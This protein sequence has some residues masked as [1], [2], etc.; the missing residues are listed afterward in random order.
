MVPGVLS[1]ARIAKNTPCLCFW[2]D[3]YFPTFWSDYFSS[4]YWSIWEPCEWS[5]LSL[6][7]I[8]WAK[9]L[10]F[11][12]VSNG[13]WRLH[14]WGI[15]LVWKHLF[16][17]ALKWRLHWNCFKCFFLN[18]FPGECPESSIVPPTTFILQF[19]YLWLNWAFLWV[20]I[21][22]NQRQW[23]IWVTCEWFWL[24]VAR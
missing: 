20:V 9:K 1:F 2:L 15:H 23:S 21:Y 6:G 5:R 11:I 22:L 7:G 17:I 24:V 16:T 10:E 19:T 13:A 18:T 8:I 12:S 14:R 3:T 4:F